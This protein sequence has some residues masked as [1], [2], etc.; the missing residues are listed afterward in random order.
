[1]D[2]ENYLYKFELKNHNSEQVSSNKE[3]IMGFEGVSATPIGK[4][5]TKQPQYDDKLK[6]GN[7]DNP[8]TE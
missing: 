8:I 4:L 5:Y 7:L 3:L 6:L 2:K 1:M